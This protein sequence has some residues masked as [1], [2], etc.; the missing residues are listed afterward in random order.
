MTNKFQHSMK[1][2]DAILVIGG[3]SWP[4]FTMSFCD[5]YGQDAFDNMVSA[6]TASVGGTSDLTQR[7]V[8]NLQAGGLTGVNPGL[9][10]RTPAPAWQPPAKQYDAAPAV[11]CAHGPMVARSGKGAKG[12]WS[13]HFC[14]QP[15]GAPDQCQPI[16][17]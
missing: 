1:L 5:A 15:K 7:A 4:E 13:G 14:P 16:W 9:D 2:G 6:F 17:G 11:M 3:D 10:S 8:Q 12:P